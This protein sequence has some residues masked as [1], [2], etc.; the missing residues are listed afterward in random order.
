MQNSPHLRKQ[1]NRS[2]VPRF[3][4]Q[5][6]AGGNFT[7]LVFLEISDYEAVWIRRGLSMLM[8]L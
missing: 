7:L 4:V 8:L 2:E 6:F 3:S 1:P 5:M